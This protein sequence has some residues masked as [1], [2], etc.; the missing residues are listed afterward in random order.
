VKKNAK[1][2]GYHLLEY[3]TKKDS[4]HFFHTG[5]V[6]RDPFPGRAKEGSEGDTQK[7]WNRFISSLIRVKGL[8]LLIQKRKEGK[9]KTKKREVQKDEKRKAGKGRGRDNEAKLKRGTILPYRHD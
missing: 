9:K 1:G 8:S 3:E 7:K 2:R 6:S 4:P 5:R